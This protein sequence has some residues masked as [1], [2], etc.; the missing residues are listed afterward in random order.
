MSK[1]SS[2]QRYSQ[3]LEWLGKKT[4]KPINK[5]NYSKSNLYKSKGA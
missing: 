4:T 3:L 1:T 2:K 5:P